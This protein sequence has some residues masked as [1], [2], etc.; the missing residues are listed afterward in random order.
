MRKSRSAKIINKKIKNSILVSIEFSSI[1]KIREPYGGRSKSLKR[2]VSD[3]KHVMATGNSLSLK[4]LNSEF[5][6][7]TVRNKENC[8]FKNVDDETVK[9]LRK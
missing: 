2:K 8:E 9:N 1:A 6:A 7:A 5:K 3:E 4:K